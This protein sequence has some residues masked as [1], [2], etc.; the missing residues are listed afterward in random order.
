MKMVTKIFLVLS[1]FFVLV[2]GASFFS[3]LEVKF[4]FYLFGIWSLYFL[5]F[6]I[7]HTY[8][9]ARIRFNKFQWLGIFFFSIVIFGIY[10]YIL[11]HR[12][13]IYVWDM[14]TYYYGNIR[15]LN[16]F[17]FQSFY[18]VIKGII[19]SI[20]NQDYSDFL[21]CFTTMLFHFTD[22]SENSFVLCYVITFVI[23]SFIVFLMVVKKMIVHFHLKREN[24]ILFLSS[25]LYVLFP[26]VHK[27][28]L[29]GQPDI[30]GLIFI[31]LI[32]LLTIDYNFL[33]FEWKRIF[34][35]LF[36]LICLCASRRWYMYWILGYGLSFGGYI[37]F[38]LFFDR[39][40]TFFKRKLK[41]IV[42]SFL[43]IAF[44]ILLC[45]F[46]MFDRS[47]TQDFSHYFSWNLG[48]YSYEVRNQFGYLGILFVL[49]VFCGL[50][51]GFRKRQ[52]RGFTFIF[53]CT[54]LFCFIEFVK[55]QNMY[56][57]QSL[58][59]LPTYLYLLLLCIIFICSFSQELW[60][61]FFRC[62][63][64][65]VLCLNWGG[66]FFGITYPLFTNILIHPVWR[67]DYSN[68]GKMVH[69]IQQHTYSSDTVYINAASADSYCAQTFSSYLLP[70]TSLVN[71]IVYESS[72]DAVH[73]FPIDNIATAK[74]IFTTNVDIESTGAVKGHIIPAINTALN[75]DTIVRQRFRLVQTFV[76]SDQVTFYAYKRI[77][78]LD[79]EEANYWIST[80][81]DISKKY[82]DLFEKR[83]KL[84]IRLNQL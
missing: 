30:I 24:L 45:L 14:L 68:I 55:L 75:T 69:F 37:L 2:L 71:T 44:S 50:I 11:F 1:F 26:L 28:A 58:I 70:D 7:Y 6:L 33:K 27:A 32:I 18:L 53:C 31:F 48:G 17:D 74:Y 76:M 38:Q 72:I 62:L 21:L 83:I 42:C 16:W 43:L 51:Y 52:F 4:S 19:L 65:F 61:K 82:P 22:R 36:S 20:F 64:V 78:P 54:W 34:L 12:N 8:R 23:P 40:K 79:L 57:H 5:F 13:K 59:L 15:L 81:S 66:S 39:D 60:I 56:Y 3:I 25:L 80:F 84:F 63:F 46:P 77:L 41:N 35:I 10:C 47:L 67:T 29:D 49:M 9:V 73:G